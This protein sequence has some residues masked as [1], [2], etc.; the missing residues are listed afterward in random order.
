MLLYNKETSNGTGSSD[1]VRL[2]G[3]DGSHNPG[4]LFDYNNAFVVGVN[5]DGSLN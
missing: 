5:K 4:T 2:C 3:S 1:G